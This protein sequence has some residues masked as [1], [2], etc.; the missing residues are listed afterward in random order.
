ML[1]RQLRLLPQTDPRPHQ[2]PSPNWDLMEKDMRDTYAAAKDS[3]IEILFRDVYTINGDRQ[4][5]RRWVDMT[6]SIFGM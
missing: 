3:H 4:R 2:R 5:L 1:G 6:K